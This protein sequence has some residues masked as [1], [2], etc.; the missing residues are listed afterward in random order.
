MRILKAVIV[1]CV[2][3]MA[4]A[5]AVPE[6]ALA[7]D[8]K[9]GYIEV[10]RILEEYQGYK[11]ARKELEKMRAD[12]EAE[13]KER[14]TKLENER[15]KL[16]DSLK[17]LSEKKRREREQEF[18]AKAQELE[19]WRLEQNKELTDREEGLLKR[20]EGDVR[21]ALEKVAKKKYLFVVRKDIM[22]YMAEDADDLTD[23]VLKVLEK[24]DKGK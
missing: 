24:A 13:F 6:T 1:L 10:P 9:I 7:R 22:L 21:K 2:G 15:R 14:A 19:K 8:A 4:G 11:R 20:L 16:Q 23:K 17:L 12:R 3:I 5:C 18:M